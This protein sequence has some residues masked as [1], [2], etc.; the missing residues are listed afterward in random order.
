MARSVQ[1]GHLATLRRYGG[2]PAYGVVDSARAVLERRPAAYLAGARVKRGRNRL[3]ARRGRT[4][5]LVE[6]Y[7][8]SGNTFLAAWIHQHNPHVEL[9]SHVHSVAHIKYAAKADIPA[10]VVVR[11]PLDCI[12]SHLTMRP[13]LE[14]ALAI[15]RYSRF[16]IGV[17]SLAGHVLVASFEVVTA[18]P[19]AVVDAFN[20]RFSRDLVIGRMTAE[21]R[22]VVFDQ[23]DELARRRYGSV[24]ESRVSRPSAIRTATKD[25]LQTMLRSKRL[26][27]LLTEAQ[28]TY[29]AVLRLTSLGPECPNPVP[30][31]ETDGQ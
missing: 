6:G 19:P 17:L 31:E 16:N 8:R 9:A 5:V 24:D 27:P 28:Q 23:I 22:A 1:G 29:E 30:S 26:N 18:Q 14:P 25:Q 20:R 13:G 21:S 11:R 15:A 7:P 3:V 2:T 10:V 12:A 4:D